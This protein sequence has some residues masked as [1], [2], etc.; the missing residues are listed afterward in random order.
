MYQSVQC[1]TS[2]HVIYHLFINI[3]VRHRA[4]VLATCYCTGCPG[5]LGYCYTEHFIIQTETT[6]I[7]GLS[8]CYSLTLPTL[9]FVRRCLIG[10]RFRPGD[11]H[12]SAVRLWWPDVA[13]LSLVWSESH[14]W[15]VGDPFKQHPVSYQI[16]SEDSGPQVDWQSELAAQWHQWNRSNDSWV[17][18]FQRG[19]GN[20]WVW[21]VRALE[22]GAQFTKIGHK[23]NI[24]LWMT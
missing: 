16:A 6:L 11:F 1:R 3:A 2:R 21:K 8:L 20:W 22:R 17:T 13:S 14:L 4:R 19:G 24:L 12:V 9:C 5:L 7:T 15:R 10:M 18:T 23:N